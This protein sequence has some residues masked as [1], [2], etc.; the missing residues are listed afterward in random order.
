LAA[1]VRWVAPLSWSGVDLFFVLSG[2]LIGGILLDQRNTE[3]YFKTFYIRRVCRIFPFYFLWLALFFLL[4]AV[5]LPRFQQIGALFAPQG[6]P[7]WSYVLFVQNFHMAKTAMLGTSWLAPTWSL[8]VE[9]Q[10]YLLAPLMIW[11]IPIRKLPQVLIALTLCVPALRVYLYL[12]HP[13]IF[14]YVLLPCRADTLL[15]GILCACWV[16]NEAGRH[17]LEQN[18]DRLCLALV[19][20]LAGAG[21]LTA[22]AHAQR[23]FDG[24]TSFEMVSFG[25][26]WMALLYACLLLIVATRKQGLMVRLTRFTPLRHLGIISYSV[27]LMHMAINSLVHDLILGKEPH[28]NNLPGGMVTLAA[29][30]LTLVLAAFSW[31]YFE[32]PI[33]RWGHS[34]SYTTPKSPPGA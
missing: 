28:L 16:R 10:F 3:N 5:L 12:L 15:M 23:S 11:L 26:S 2:F 25:Y 30:L 4:P 24:L 17:W 33:I 27:Y 29:L 6:I 32:K 19:V 7:Q 18:P 31:H 9:E 34:F 1:C 8:A 21:Y 13:G 14:E 20:L 22:V